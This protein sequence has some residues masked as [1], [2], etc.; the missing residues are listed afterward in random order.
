M[1]QGKE[2]IMGNQYT[3][4]DPL[5]TGFLRLSMRGGFPMKELSAYTA[6]Q[7]PYDAA[8][9]GKENCRERAESFDLIASHS[10]QTVGL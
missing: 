7:E 2:W 3:V 10:G 9:D 6:W 4:V 5:R 1:L 8:P